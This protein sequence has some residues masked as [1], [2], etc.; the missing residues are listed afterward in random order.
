MSTATICRVLGGVLVLLIGAALAVGGI[1]LGRGG[2]EAWPDVVANETTVRRTASGMLGMSA[3][4]LIAGMAASSNLPW[5]GWAAAIATIV[6]VLAA[7]WVNYALFGD[8]RPMHTG[9]NLV[10]GAMIL[11]LLWFGYATQAR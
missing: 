3:F 8:I 7:F 9:T 1:Q 6:V 5:G 10:V 2:A 11:V 4:L